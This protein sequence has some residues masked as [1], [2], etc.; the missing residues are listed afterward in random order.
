MQYSVTQEAAAD[1]A[2]LTFLDRGGQSSRGLLQFFQILEGEELLSGSEPG[3]LSAHPPA[4]R[5]ARRVCPQPRRPFALFRRARHARQYRDAEADQ[6]KARRFPVAARHDLGGLSREGPVGSGALRAGHRLLPDP[7]A[8]Q[9]A[10]DHRRADPGF[11]EG[12]VFSRAE[13]ADAVRERAHRRRG[14]AL[15]GS[16]PPRARSAVAAH[17]ARSGLHRSRTIPR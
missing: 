15:R 2:A 17:L 8:R 10:A 16:R 6:G 12:S 13:G 1:Q 4:D 9:G 5:P 11:S 3:S 7:K 14:A